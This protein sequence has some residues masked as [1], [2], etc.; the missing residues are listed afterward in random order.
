MKLKGMVGGDD[1]N[2]IVCHLE[3]GMRTLKGLYTLTR[4]R[5]DE[6]KGDWISG[7]EEEG[8]EDSLIKMKVNT[9]D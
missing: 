5:V 8:E 2:G 6:R 7:D 4:D 3:N 9:E 1:N